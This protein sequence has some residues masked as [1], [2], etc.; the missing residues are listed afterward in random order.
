MSIGCFRSTW[1]GSERG[2]PLED[3]EPS[4]FSALRA[5]SAWHAPSRPRSFPHLEPPGPRDASGLGTWL[6]PGHRGDFSG[7]LWR[8]KGKRGSGPASGSR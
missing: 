7:D 4:T 2:V 3:H 8:R 1:S 5:A 6:G